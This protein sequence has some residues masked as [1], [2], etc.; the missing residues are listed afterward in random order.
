[1]CWLYRRPYLNVGGI[2]ISTINLIPPG[3]IQNVCWDN[4][5]PNAELNAAFS[6]EV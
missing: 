1:M 6:V 2:K 3:G 5:P 4:I